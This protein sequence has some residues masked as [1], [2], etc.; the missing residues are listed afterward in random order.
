MI[1]YRKGLSPHSWISLKALLIIVI[2]PPC[3]LINEAVLLDICATILKYMGDCP[4]KKPRLSTELTD[5]IFEPA[6]SHDQ[7]L[8]DELYSQLLKQLNFNP[9]KT[10]E[11][12]GWELLWM[13]TGLFSCSPTL[14]RT[15]NFF[16]RS[17]APQQPLATEIYQHFCTTINAAARCY[18]P[19]LVEVDAIQ[20]QG[21][22]N[23]TN[24]RIP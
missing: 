9:T 14:Q 11:E 20:K 2:I 16:L 8:K 10:S 22:S 12:R 6:L 15:V 5:A 23:L 4:T 3:I 1:S 7:Q 19:H 24:C 21:N 17:R 13:V 18:P